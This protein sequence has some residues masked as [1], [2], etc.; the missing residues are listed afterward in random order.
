PAE[1]GARLEEAVV[2]VGAQR[3]ERNATVGVALGAGHLGAAEATG[4]LDLH[5]L[6]ARPDGGGERSLHRAPEGD[7]VLELLRNRLGDQLGVEL[8]ALDLEN[9]HLDRL[10]GHAVELAAKRVDLGAGLPDHDSGARGVDVHLYLVLVLADRDV[11]EPGV[12]E[13]AL[14]VVADADV[15]EQVVGELALVEPGRLPVVD[16]ADAQDLGMDLVTHRYLPSSVVVRVI[17]MW[18]VRFRIRVARPSARGRYR[19]SVG[20]SST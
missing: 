19:F 16:V 20:P 13:L 11:R 9:V 18:L 17:V 14:D 1:G 8:R 7:A 6:R 3:V 5:A 15:L 10:L 12:G 2:D 4:H